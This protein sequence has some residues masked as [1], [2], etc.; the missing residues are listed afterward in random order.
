MKIEASNQIA[1]E[2]TFIPFQA[3]KGM[4]D[5]VAALLMIAA[6][7]VHNTEPGTLQ[8]LALQEDDSRFA[9][10]DFFPDSKARERHFAGDVAGGLKDAAEEAIKGGWQEG[11]MTHVENGRVIASNI[12]S[13][14][15]LPARIAVRIVLQAKHGQEEN[16][17][18]VLA[19]A[20][21]VVN[22]TEPNTLLWYA[23]RINPSRFA[24]FDVFPNEEAKS[25]HLSGKVAAALKSKSKEMVE[26]G[27]EGGVV[28]NIKTYRVLSSAY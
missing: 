28:A 11:I 23:I 24:I 9:I 22:D 26:G 15:P 10:A 4:E 7:Q 8:W 21:L 3:A 17:A 16:L 1:H 2:G 5:D 6:D 19:S 12:R 27:W 13:A 18:R 20:A 25:A 14:H